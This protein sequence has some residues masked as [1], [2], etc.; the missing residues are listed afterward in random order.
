MLVRNKR[1]YAADLT[2]T[3][4]LFNFGNPNNNILADLDKSNQ[5]LDYN[6]HVILVSAIVTSDNKRGLLLNQDT[7]CL[8]SKVFTTP[9][10]K[11][12]R[13]RNVNETH[14]EVLVKED[15]RVD[16]N[17]WLSLKEGLLS[18]AAV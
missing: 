12:A 4:K 11:G 8:D 18:S 9:K 5:T 10:H 13:A 16:S 2:L 1:Q 17:V 7:Q 15:A 14:I 6:V 3:A